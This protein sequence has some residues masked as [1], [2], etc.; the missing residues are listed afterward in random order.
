MSWFFFYLCFF[1][2]QFWRFSQGIRSKP[3]I[4]LICQERPFLNRKG[5]AII[6]WHVVQSGK[7]AALSDR[8]CVIAFRLQSSE[9]VWRQD[10]QINHSLKLLHTFVSENKILSLVFAELVPP[11]FLLVKADTALGW[12]SCCFGRLCSWK[13]F[14][15]RS[16]FSVSTK[17][18]ADSH[19]TVQF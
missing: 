3:V 11:C 2:F 18:N 8:H 9:K 19:L 14:S 4:P 1:F 17:F 5:L 15:P 16:L 13:G 6:Q 10:K 7:V 12:D